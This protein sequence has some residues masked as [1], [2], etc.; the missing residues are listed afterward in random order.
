V[1]SI[2]ESLVDWE[3][4]HRDGYV[5]LGRLLVGDDVHH[6]QDR[7]NSIMLGEADVDYDRL[8]MQLD[9]TSGGDL[10]EQTLGFKGP[11]LAYRKIEGLEIDELFRGWAQH[12]VAAKICRRIYG[13]GVP[14]ATF[15][16]MF[17]N[18]P[19]E[20]GTP[21]PWHQDRWAW[22]DRDPLVTVYTA[23][24]AATEANGCV[25]II[26]GSQH[27][28]VNPW[29]PSAFL[30]E[31]HY[32]VHCPPAGRRL[33]AGARRGRSLAQLAHSPFRREQG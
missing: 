29:D 9:P 27:S 28:L 15:R 12:P 32:A 33:G 2:T 20:A 26:A 10:E 31:A 24:D 6:L 3:R 8:M 16:S 13:E 1:T 17:M 4:F 11:S 21:L 23:L 14:V 19:A 22:L 25:H 30:E 18:K 5:R 7:I